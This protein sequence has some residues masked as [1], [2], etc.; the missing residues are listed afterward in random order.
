MKACYRAYSYEIW[1]FIES[2]VRFTTAWK[3]LKNTVVKLGISLFK[4]ECHLNYNDDGSLKIE[5]NNDAHLYPDCGE[6]WLKR[7]DPGI[8]H[9]NQ[10]FYKQVELSEQWIIFSVQYTRIRYWF[11]ENYYLVPPP[12]PVCAYLQR[13]LTDRFT[14]VVKNIEQSTYME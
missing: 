10:R 12:F 8:K 5:P 13:L 2:Y 11:L 7:I 3:A 9:L 14:T 1:L 6:H 4:W